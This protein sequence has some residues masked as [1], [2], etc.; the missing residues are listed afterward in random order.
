MC[1]VPLD[2]GFRK[3]ACSSVIPPRPVAS[4]GQ[5]RAGD[6]GDQVPAPGAG[7]RGG[8]HAP[9]RAPARAVQAQACAHRR[10]RLRHGRELPRQGGAHS[11]SSRK[12]T[13]WCRAPGWLAERRFL[14]R[15]C[16]WAFPKTGHIG[17]RDWGSKRT[18]RGPP[19]PPGGPA[20][21]GT[22]PCRRSSASARRWRPA[23]PLATSSGGRRSTRTTVRTAH[24]VLVCLCGG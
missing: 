9:A 5:A 17:N 24:A 4:A 8:G 1:G 19:R 11:P 22:P 14:A 13:S 16:Y 23:G 18:A 7:T 2:N 15:R 3:C 10:G 6:C 20:P 12:H 21:G